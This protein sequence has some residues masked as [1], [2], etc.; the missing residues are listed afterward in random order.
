MKWMASE[1]ERGSTR[2]QFV[3]M[4]ATEKTMNSGAKADKI[5]K[6]QSLNEAKDVKIKADGQK[7]KDA[8]AG[9]SS[10]MAVSGSGEAAA[11]KLGSRAKKPELGNSEEE[12]EFNNGQVYDRSEMDH[13]HAAPESDENHPRCSGC[14]KKGLRWRNSL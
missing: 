5:A 4:N 13:L 7:S 3:I 1:K 14:T 9:S 8:S 10:Q 2:L 11:K 12:E 6:D